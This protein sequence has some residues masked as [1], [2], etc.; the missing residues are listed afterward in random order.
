M[1]ENNKKIIFNKEI[2]DIINGLALVLAFLI[3]GIILLFK[4]SFFGEAT[5]VI[6]IVFIG[7]V[8][9]NV[10]I[11]QKYCH[12]ILNLEGLNLVVVYF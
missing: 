9:V 6:K 10:E 3:L 1:K 11:R 2:D 4:E 8:N 7:L 12:I 5:F